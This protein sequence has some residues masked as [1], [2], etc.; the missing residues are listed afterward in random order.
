MTSLTKV[1]C[2]LK[3]ISTQL[4]MKDTI[5]CTQLEKS[6]TMRDLSMG[7]NERLFICIPF[8]FTGH[9]TDMQ[10]GSLLMTHWVI[11]FLN[12]FG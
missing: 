12:D 9:L 6:H 1:A 11:C 5:Q 4:H 7:E 8:N 10:S 2:C 3:P